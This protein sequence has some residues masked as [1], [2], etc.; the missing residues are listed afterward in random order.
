MK[1]LGQ[2]I[3]TVEARLARDRDEVIGPL[4]TLV[5]ERTFATHAALVSWTRELEL[6]HRAL[7]SPESDTGLCFVVVS[8]AGPGEEPG[9][10]ELGEMEGRRPVKRDC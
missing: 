6:H 1:D 7:R 4:Q 8:I 10:R 9:V 2:R 5:E 3:S